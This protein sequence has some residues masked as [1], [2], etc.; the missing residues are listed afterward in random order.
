[1][2]IIKEA[3]FEIYFF[4][5]PFSRHTAPGCFELNKRKQAILVDLA[6][7]VPFEA[8]Q[9][10]FDSQLGLPRTVVDEGESNKS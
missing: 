10:I 5:I 8:V 7:E 6:C 1:M 9:E 4:L 3:I 2:I